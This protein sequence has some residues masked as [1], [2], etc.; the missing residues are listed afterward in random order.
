VEPASEPTHPFRP[1]K[2]L[3]I[4]LSMIG[5]V[6]VGVAFAFFLEY[7]DQ[8]IKNPEDLERRFGF[9]VLAVIQDVSKQRTVA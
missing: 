7:L 6:M 5:S 3:N 8:T 1:K 9:P 4:L 2:K